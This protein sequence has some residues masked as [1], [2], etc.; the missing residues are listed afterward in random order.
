MRSTYLAA[1]K[2]LIRELAR[3]DAK[4][5]LESYL[6]LPDQ[7]NQP[8]SLSKLFERLLSSA[9]NANM[10][11]SVVG[12]SIGGIQ[13]LGLGMVFKT[14]SPVASEPRYCA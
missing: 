7:S 14:L 8:V 6:S 13:N 2:F 12:G 4:D 11:A 3:P 1:K 10:K 9:Q 5:I